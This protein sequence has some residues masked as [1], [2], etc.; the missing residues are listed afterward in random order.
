MK[1]A[2]VVFVD[3]QTGEIVGELKRIWQEGEAI[4]EIPADGGPIADA[5]EKLAPPGTHAEMRKAG[6]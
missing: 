2:D 3:D 4:D 1:V 6:I 5:I